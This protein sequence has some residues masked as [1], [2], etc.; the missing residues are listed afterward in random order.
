MH[1][2]PP[3]VT[4]LHVLCAQAMALCQL[5]PSIDHASA[6]ASALSTGY[7]D[8][9][10]KKLRGQCI[11]Q[12]EADPAAHQHMIAKNHPPQ[13]TQ[14]GD[15]LAGI[16]NAQCTAIQL[17]LSATLSFPCSTL[18]SFSTISTRLVNMS[19]NRALQHS[20]A[21]HIAGQHQMITAAS[22]C[23]CAGLAPH[24]AVT[25]HAA[26]ASCCCLPSPSACASGL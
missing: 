19:V 6:W 11:S 20:L 15:N 26:A 9:G 5:A 12:A 16:T 23:L 21:G 14:Q 13:A 22:R 4:T 24:M 2:W 7:P 25:A 17:H 18:G 10:L 1:V 3:R 8:T